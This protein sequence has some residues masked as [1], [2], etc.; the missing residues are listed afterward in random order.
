LVNKVVK[1][2]RR[3]IRFIIS[4]CRSVT[5]IS[6]V[7]LYEHKQVE[8]KWYPSYPSLTRRMKHVCLCVQL[9]HSMNLLGNRLIHTLIE[10]FLSIFV[11]I[12]DFIIMCVHIVSSTYMWPLSLIYSCSRIMTWT[13]F[14]LKSAKTFQAILRLW[15][16]DKFF[17]CSE[18]LHG[19]CFPAVISQGKL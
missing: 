5:S 17:R 12:M 14:C 16:T 6:W 9:N 2:I 18:P 3:R 4:F 1:I 19:R 11:R 7:N 8:A 13:S 10:Y 15:L